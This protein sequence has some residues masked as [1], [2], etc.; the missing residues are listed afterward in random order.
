MI[1][2]ICRRWFLLAVLLIIPQAARASD[3]EY[4]DFTITVDGKQSGNS[5]MG[6]TKQADGSLTVNYQGVVRISGV[7]FKYEFNS[8][9]TETWKDGRLISLKAS[10]NDNGKKVNMTATAV[11]PGLRV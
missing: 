3:T 1:K 2:N 10:T 5:L 9:T 11:G 8:Q 6:I 4:R 7:F